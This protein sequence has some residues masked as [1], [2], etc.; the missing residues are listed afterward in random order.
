MD[1]RARGTNPLPEP[2]P[3]AGEGTGAG[4]INDGGSVPSGQPDT[5][6]A[7]HAA[8]THADN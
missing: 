6:A 3:Q 5:E 7:D 2:P 8:V 4:Q 1:V